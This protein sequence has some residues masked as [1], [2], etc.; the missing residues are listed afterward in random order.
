MRP[1]GFVY[2][3]PPP[4]PTLNSLRRSGVHVYA[5]G[6]GDFGQLGIALANN[7]GSKAGTAGS[8]GAEGCA[9][10]PM[11][12]DGMEGKDVVHVAAGAFNTALLTGRFAGC[13]HSYV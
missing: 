1:P 12:V 6:R 4:T 11:R 8:S 2:P 3:R 10:S 7:D 9:L 13:D 5:W